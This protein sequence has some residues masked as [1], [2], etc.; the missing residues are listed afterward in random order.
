VGNKDKEGEQAERAMYGGSK[1]RKRT[2]KEVR[3][4]G[5][6]EKA[7]SRKRRETTEAGK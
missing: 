7:G 6:L 2:S 1:E 4:R 5:R 3:R